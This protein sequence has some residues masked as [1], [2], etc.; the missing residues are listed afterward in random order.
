[1]T[2]LAFLLSVMSDE[3]VDVRLRI[4]AAK[5][6]LPYVAKRDGG[7]EKPSAEVVS[8]ETILGGRK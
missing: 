7:E 3:S 6:A 2:P 4:A 8:W 5:A 1:M